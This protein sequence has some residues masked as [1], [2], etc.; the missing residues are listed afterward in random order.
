ME[1]GLW[2]ALENKA[3][4]I[5]SMEI[6][7]SNDRPSG[8]QTQQADLTLDARELGKE[9]L[10]W[11]VSHAELLAA[12]E[13][14][15]SWPA[16]LNRLETMLRQVAPG[17]ASPCAPAEL[18]LRNGQSYKAGLVLAADG[19]RSAMRRRLGLG[20]GLRQYPQ[21]ALVC[22][23][24]SERPHQ[25]IAMQWFQQGA[26]LA[27]LPLKDPHQVSMVFSLPNE[28]LA[29][30][31][32]L[33]DHAFARELSLATGHRLGELGSPTARVASP[34]AMTLVPQTSLGRVLLL[35]DAAHTVHPL[36][37]YG[38]NLGFQDLLCFDAFLSQRSKR[39]SQ[40][41][42]EPAML[43]RFAAQRH[44]SVQRVQ[45]GLDGLWRLIQP[46]PQFFETSRQLGL[47]A[48]QSVQPLRHQLIQLALHGA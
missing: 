16:N 46:G 21:T 19:Q 18:S 40:D 22:R 2:Q 47:R 33:D 35:G 23:F 43:A 42:G 29:H 41:L 44:K 39:S 8:P 7:Q 5:V 48:I 15:A 27:L 6:R 3:Q 25:S 30:L 32:S 12:V 28:R 36:A 9:N 4:P 14:P 34:L 20:W 10:A 17:G 26:V 37:G 24:E 38:L 45:W 11:I 31:Q 13:S 1:F